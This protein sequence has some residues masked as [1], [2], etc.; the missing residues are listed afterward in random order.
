MWFTEYLGQ[1]V[2]TD[3][4]LSCFHRSVTLF[5]LWEVYDVTSLTYLKETSEQVRKAKNLT[6][7]HIQIT[8]TPSEAGAPAQSHEGSVINIFSKTHNLSWYLINNM[9]Y[10]TKNTAGKCPD[11]A[12]KIFTSQAW[13][14]PENN[15]VFFFFSCFKTS[16]QLLHLFKESKSTLL[17]SS[18]KRL[19]N[20]LVAMNVAGNV[21]DILSVKC[22]F[23]CEN[24]AGKVPTSQ[25]KYSLLSPQISLK[26][27]WSVVKDF[28]F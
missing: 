23:V 2:W 6:S 4:L 18:R 25:Q 1:T 22:G 14:C 8:V 5:T 15:S 19:T 21:P 27:S 24:T 11:I 28:W 7:H 10:Q 20:S 16:P 13:K 26:M 17:R 3:V 9:F 12:A